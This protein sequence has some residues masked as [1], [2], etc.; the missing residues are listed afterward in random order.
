MARW[1][2]FLIVVISLTFGLH[3]YVWARLVRDAALPPPWRMVATVALVLLGASLPLSFLLVRTL[4][5]RA[6]RFLA[7]PAYVWM[8]LLLFL[9]FLLVTGDLLRFLA[10]PLLGDKL[11]DPE[12]R[13]MLARAWA[14]A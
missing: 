1:L 12:R 6:G 8:G 2:P 5:P 10:G 7:W 3:Y 13:R 4:G 14:G 11:R 9:F